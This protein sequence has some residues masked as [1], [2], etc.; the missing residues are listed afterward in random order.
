[1]SPYRVNGLNGLLAHVGEVGR[2]Y[3]LT[4]RIVCWAVT[5]DTNRERALQ[6][7]HMR[8]SGRMASGAR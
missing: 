4:S 8:W 1:V 3:E 5:R 2:T 6:I 7:G